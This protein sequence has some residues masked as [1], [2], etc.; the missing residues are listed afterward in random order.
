M[1]GAGTGICGGKDFWIRY[2]ESGMTNSG[3]YGRWQW[4]RWERWAHMGGI[5]R[6]CWGPVVSDHR[7]GSLPIRCCATVIIIARLFVIRR[8]VYARVTKVAW[9]LVAVMLYCRWFVGQSFHEMH[10]FV[11]VGVRRKW[12]SAKMW[13]CVWS[14]WLKAANVRRSGWSLVPPHGLTTTASLVVSFSPLLIL[15]LCYD[16]FYYYSQFTQYSVDDVI[17]KE[18][19]YEMKGGVCL[20]LL[21]FYSDPLLISHRVWR[22]N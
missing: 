5:G 14:R 16:F 12:A 15:T 1:S 8:W 9:P 6:A 10:M 3:S 4:R 20:L 2:F 22:K 19:H 17:G 13:N 21:L 18:G 7:P 11:V